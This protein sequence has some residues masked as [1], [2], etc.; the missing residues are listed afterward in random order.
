MERNRESAP[1]PVKTPDFVL[2]LNP[3]AVLVDDALGRLAAFFARTLEAGACGARLQYADGSFQ[4]GA[5]MFPSP[6]QVAL[7]LLPVEK[8]PRGHRL[9]DTAWNGRYPSRQWSGDTPFKVDFVL[10]ATL[11]MRGETL[12][13]IGG[14]DEG[15]FMYCEEMDWCLRAQQAGWGVYALP[16][17]RVVHHEAQS[18]RQTPWPSFINLWRSRMRFYRKHRRRYFPGHMLLVCAILRM[19]LGCR[20]RAAWRA[21]THG[22]VTGEAIAAEL[23]AY[24]TVTGL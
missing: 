19:A 8:L 14:L 9:Y 17:A 23:T 22:N 1:S 2:L 7:D 15:Y 16:T 18:S 12:L 20:S 11:M 10:G 13:Q 4:H 3:D 21:Y 24:K 5:F 6:A